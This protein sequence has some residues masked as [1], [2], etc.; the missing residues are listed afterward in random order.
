MSAKPETE[1][2][3]L[4]AM[5]DEG[6]L[7][8]QEGALCDRIVQTYLAAEPGV[9]A[10]VRRREG[11]AGVSYTHTEKRRLT[12]M[13]AWEDEREI[14]EEEYL[15]L[16]KGAD[17][18]LRPIEKRRYTVPMGDLSLEIDLYPFWK[19]QAVLEVELPSEETALSL[20]PYIT[21]LREVTADRRYKNVSLAGCIPPED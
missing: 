12:A 2:K 16:L 7:A 15:A 1:R 21:V 13:T 3:F 10:R 5:P 14:T 19:R 8:A 17:P 4:I 18:T 9:T 11:S 6:F 20:P